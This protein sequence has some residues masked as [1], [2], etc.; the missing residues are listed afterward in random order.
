MAYQVGFWTELSDIVATELTESDHMVSTFQAMPY[1]K[2][3]HPVYG[4][5]NFDEQ[6]AREAAANVNSQIRGQDLDIDYD[7]KQYSGEAA[8]WVKKAEAR[9]DGLWLTVEWTKK[10]WEAIKT[11]AYR[12]F[13]PE[14]ADQWTHPKTKITHKNV[15][16]GGGITNRPFLKDILPLNMSELF[17]ERHKQDTEEGTGMDP[18][19]LRK[20][21]GLP[22]DATDEQVN[23]KLGELPEDFVIEP[24]KAPE[25]KKTED[26]KKVEEKELE[27]VG[28]SEDLIK[29]SETNPA[30]KQLTDMIGS[31]QETVVKQGAAL[32]LAETTVIVKKLSE[33]GNGKALPTGVQEKLKE[34]LL[35]PTAENVVKLMESLNAAG[36][37][38]ELGESGGAGNHGDQDAGSATKKF[39]DKVQ[40]LVDKDKLSYGDAVE[41]VALTEPDLFE[42]H[43]QASYAFRE[44]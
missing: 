41:R 43:R 39:N 6:V 27:P 34:T 4:E 26:E 22:E 16:F 38:V 18:K 23:A 33:P 2:Y 11:K 8:G 17:E 14:F 19:K 21:L 29:L 10:A 32:Q 24:P 3:T 15:L 7:H 28:L 25:E 1:G 44:N 12:Y 30:I 5:I 40:E 36:G 35:A 42:A 31:L 37:Y 9:S 20:L 13:S